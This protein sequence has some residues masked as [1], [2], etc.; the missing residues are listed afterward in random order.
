ME[1]AFWTTNEDL[2]LVAIAGRNTLDVLVY[3]F[4]VKM[5]PVY[6]I[7]E[8]IPSFTQENSSTSTIL[9]RLA[10]CTQSNY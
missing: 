8:G 6:F 10:V 2:N 9:C 7:H 5:I 3:P 1:V 4:R